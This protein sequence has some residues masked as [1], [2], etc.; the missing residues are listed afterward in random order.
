MSD[1]PTSESRRDAIKAMLGG[2]AT[3][4]LMNLVGVATAQ[5]GDQEEGKKDLPHVDEEKDPTA[6]A[7]E[8]RHDA[9]AE[10][11]K[12]G[13]EEPKVPKVPKDQTCANCQFIQA[14]TGEWR[15]CQLFPGKS[16][17]AKGWCASW[18][19]KANV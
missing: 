5:A 11:K 4:P 1:K 6:L 8:Y 3:V 9:T 14:G 7:L 10:Y 2:L 16:V 13:E 15:L 12:K 19:K 17:S 18:L